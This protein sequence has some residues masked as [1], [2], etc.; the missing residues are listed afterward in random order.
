[1]VDLNGSEVILDRGEPG[2]EY[3]VDVRKGDRWQV[4][5]EDADESS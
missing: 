3:F 1:M 5:A 4:I 2:E